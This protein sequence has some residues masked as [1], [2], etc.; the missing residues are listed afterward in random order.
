MIEPGQWQ[1]GKR[2]GNW[3]KLY[4]DDCAERIGAYGNN[5]Q[6]AC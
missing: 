2:E 6:Q 5:D 3:Y 4:H 1:K